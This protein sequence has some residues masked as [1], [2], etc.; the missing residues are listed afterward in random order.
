MITLILDGYNV[1]GR[2]PEL[3][4][5]WDRNPQA[6]REALVAFCRGYRSRRKDL[7]RLYVV[8]DGK[9]AYA[10]VL[11]GSSGGVTICFTQG[12]EADAY[13]V[14]MIEADRDRRAFA[15]VSDDKELAHNV[16]M[17][18]AR[19]LCVKEFY[20]SV[21]PSKGRQ[22]PSREGETK[23]MPSPSAARHITEELRQHLE[24]R[25]LRRTPQKPRRP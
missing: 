17:L 19:S 18:G 25:A 8:F 7:E 22:T 1:I 2:V 11:P 6:A 4:R 5:Q 20:G 21:Q 13:I 12:E 3:N 16:K 23:S 10:H 24:A 9:A 14:Q 15:V